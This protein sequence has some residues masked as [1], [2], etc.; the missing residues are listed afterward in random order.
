MQEESNNT[1]PV[2]PHALTKYWTAL[3]EFVHRFAESERI[4]QVALWM[5]ART[6]PQVSAVVFSGV[7]IDQGK[8]WINSMRQAKKMPPDPALQAALSQLGMINDARN[9][10]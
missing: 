10:I 4:L 2:P 1:T 6:D 5:Y 9:R 8:K 3:G 7:R